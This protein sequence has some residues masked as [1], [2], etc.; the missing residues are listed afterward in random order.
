MDLDPPHILLLVENTMILPSSFYMELHKY[1]DCSSAC[2]FCVFAPFL[3]VYYVELHRV[4]AGARSQHPA[5]N[6]FNNKDEMLAEQ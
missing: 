6:G 3:G 4:A 1:N 2:F 5:L